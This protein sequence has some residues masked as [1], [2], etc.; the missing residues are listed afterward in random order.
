MPA[1]LGFF[2]AFLARLVLLLV[3][4]VVTLFILPALSGRDC[5]GAGDVEKEK[6]VRRGET[7]L[8][9]LPLSR[10]ILASIAI[11]VIFRILA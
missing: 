2:K 6:L 10:A 11:S 9:L 4:T 1:V 7:P 3:V 5:G 8:I